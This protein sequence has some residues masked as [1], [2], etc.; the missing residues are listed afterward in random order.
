MTPSVWQWCTTS[1]IVLKCAAAMCCDSRR[2]ETERNDPKREVSVYASSGQPYLAESASL[3]DGIKQLPALAKLQYE[4]HLQDRTSLGCYM[5]STAVR[6][7]LYWQKQC[8]IAYAG[9]KLDVSAHIHDPQ[10]CP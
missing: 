9:R 4:V 1:T 2:A 8:I 3:H 5:I 7:A 10:R 6:A